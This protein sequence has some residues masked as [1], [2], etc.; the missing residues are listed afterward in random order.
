MNEELQ[1]NTK[2]NKLKI[3]V[4]VILV[5]VVFVVL[6]IL[7]FSNGIDDTD[8][9]TYNINRDERI[10]LSDKQK[11]KKEQFLKSVSNERVELNESQRAEK[12][13]FIE[14]TSKDL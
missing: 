4:I 7:A 10:E 6:Y 2:A 14:S 5:L 13:R 3:A 9:K 8:D 11:L 1:N 12:K